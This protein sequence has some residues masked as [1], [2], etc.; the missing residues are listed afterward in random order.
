MLITL[1]SVCDIPL[2]FFIS[3]CPQVFDI[4]WVIAPQNG[5]TTYLIL[6]KLFSAET[7]HYSFQSE[8]SIYIQIISLI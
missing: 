2:W 8:N 7:K 5:F 1:Q 4:D 3:L 6:H